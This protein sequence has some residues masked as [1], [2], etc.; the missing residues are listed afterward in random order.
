MILSK[1]CEYAIRAS[2]YIACKSCQKKR[3]GII[4]IADA[5]GS[6]V[7]FTGKILQTMVHKN[8]I[9]S[10]K[11]PNGGFYMEDHHSVFLIDIIQTIDGNELFSACVLGLATCSNVKP[12]PVHNQIKPVR[13]QLL[14]EFS[15]KS[16]HEMVCEHEG[17]RYFL[18]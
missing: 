13:D 4:E 5:I 11:G 2:I 14:I 17:N 9:S 16:I 7:H 15:K 18:K 1:S 12:C 10:V 3:A 6:P 8:I